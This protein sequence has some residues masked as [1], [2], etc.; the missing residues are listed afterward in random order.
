MDKPFDYSFLFAQAL[1]YI[2]G[3]R[4]SSELRAENRDLGWDVVKQHDLFDFADYGFEKYVTV[5]NTAREISV[6]CVNAMIVRLM[7]QYGRSVELITDIP[8]DEFAGNVK[9]VLLD[10]TDSVLLIFKNIEE[11]PFWKLSDAEPE[12]I[13]QMLDKTGA[14][15]CRYIYYMLDYAYLQVIGHN[16]DEDDPG[17]GY[18]LFSISWFWKEY[19]GVEECQRFIIALKEY[20]VDVKNYASYFMMKSLTPNTLL[21]FRKIV[22]NRLRAFPYEQILEKRICREYKGK[23]KEYIMPETDYLR[24][25]EQF[26]DANTFSVLFGSH[27]FS[28]SIITAEWLYD[29]MKKAQAIDLTVIGTGYFKAVEQ[30]MWE[31]ICLHKN[32]GKCIKGNEISDSN[33]NNDLIDNTLGA[34]ANFYK[35]YLVILRANL[36]DTAKDYVKEAL[37]DYAEL[38]NGYFHKDNIHDWAVIDEIRN[39]S[40]CVMFLLLGSQSLSD[41]D[42][43]SLGFMKTDE[44]TDYHRLCEYV[45]YHFNQLFFVSCETGHDEMCMACIDSLAVTEPNGYTRYSGVYMRGLGNNA[46]VVRITEDSAPNEIW[47]GKYVFANTETV[48]TEPVKVKKVYE[49]GKFIGPLISQEELFEY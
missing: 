11:C 22:E 5:L 25:K 14:H 45:N 18:N 40:M 10:K 32:E 15:L 41:Q 13:S 37:F 21:N 42:M 17:R 12:C 8:Q 20:L 3:A 44:F 23:T 31:L 33:I 46:R 35:H 16:Q 2:K 26:I 1:A 6:S 9:L 30:L 43:E 19:F 48:N 27:S 34:M 29:S 24:I 47:L 38:R 4:N 28:E 36:F 7:K 49:N 39:A